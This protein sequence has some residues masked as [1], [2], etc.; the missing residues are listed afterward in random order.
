MK[1]GDKEA[2]GR[3]RAELVRESDEKGDMEAEVTEGERVW[4]GRKE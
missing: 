4:I 1:K 3:K 2:E